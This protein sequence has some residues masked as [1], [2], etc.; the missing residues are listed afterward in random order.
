M[1][2]PEN[3]IIDSM[4]A[5]KYK[6]HMEGWKIPAEAVEKTA[7][8][9]TAEFFALN[10]PYIRDGLSEF[11]FEERSKIS[12]QFHSPGYGYA[13]EAPVVCSSRL[14]FQSPEHD[15]A[16]KHEMKHG[17]HYLLCKSLFERGKASLK[18]YRLFREEVLGDPLFAEHIKKSGSSLQK[19]WFLEL[20]DASTTPTPEK[21]SEVSHILGA[22]TYQHAYFVDPAMCEAAASFEDEGLLKV[23]HM[24]N[25]L[26][27]GTLPINKNPYIGYGNKKLQEVFAEATP[28]KKALFVKAE[29]YDRNTFFAE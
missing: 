12:P 10:I 18:I 27:G 6:A 17:I 29:E 15:P 19:Q 4:E 22:L 7:N 25:R 11:Q 13:E 14:S 24:Y 26:V 9:D 20:T 8:K 2:K 5:Q 21:I 23:L 28:E 3:A 16:L 1:G